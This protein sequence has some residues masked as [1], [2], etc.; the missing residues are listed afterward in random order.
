MGNKNTAIQFL[1]D[2]GFYIALAVCIVGAAAAAW[3]TAA[4]TL[5]SIDENNR[6]IVEQGVS[7]EEKPSW[8]SSS[9]AAERDRKSTRL[10][11]SH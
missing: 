6:Q 9:S 11:S 5:D 1:K 10:N 8:S 2:K 3:A 4:R 7:G